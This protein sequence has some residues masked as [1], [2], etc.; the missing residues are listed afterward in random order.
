MGA[1]LPPVELDTAEQLLARVVQTS[2]YFL[3]TAVY[4][5]L[6]QSKNGRRPLDPDATPMVAILFD[7]CC[8]SF[9]K[10]ALPLLQR[11]D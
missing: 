3:R 7:P 8:L 2:E 10:A 6:R 5:T 4:K 9:S 1:T 11:S